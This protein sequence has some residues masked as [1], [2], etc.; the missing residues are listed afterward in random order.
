MEPLKLLILAIVQGISEL[1]PISS[2]A[3]ILILG[4]V[5]HLQVSTLLLTSLHIGTSLAILIFFAKKFF[6]GFFTKKKWVFYLKVVVSV[7]PA[8]V[9]GVLFES[10]IEGILRANWIIAG[11][12]IFW[13]IL[14]I[15]AQRKSMG[16]EDQDWENISWKQSII[17]GLAQAIALVPG[18]SR[19]GVTTL[20]GIAMG[21]DQYSALSYSFVLGL[22]VLLGSSVWELFRAL[23]ENPGISNNVFVASNLIQIAIIILVPLILG[24]IALMILKKVKREKWLL[25]FGVYRIVVGTLILAIFYL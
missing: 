5:M 12:L 7:I 23:R 3:H 16:V 15:L 25:T 8:G 18:T 4:E 11:S 13:G 10:K 14:M 9:L 24:L 22:P 20:T 17:M 2:T 19:S 6:S 1:L 21:M